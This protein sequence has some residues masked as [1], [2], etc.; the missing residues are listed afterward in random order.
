MLII[1]YDAFN[2]SYVAEEDK[3]VSPK[4]NHST[5]KKEAR[6]KKEATWSTTATMAERIRE[7]THMSLTER[8]RQEFG[9]D[10]IEDE[11]NGNPD[12][13]ASSPPPPPPPPPP[14]ETLSLNTEIVAAAISVHSMVHLP[15]FTPGVFSPAGQ[16]QGFPPVLPASGFAVFDNG[17]KHLTDEHISTNILSP[18][19][20]QNLV[21]TKLPLLPTPAPGEALPLLPTVAQPQQINIPSRVNAQPQR[22]EFPM[23]T[24]LPGGND[25]VPAITPDSNS[26][27]QQIGSHNFQ[28]MQV[29]P[30]HVQ[31][32]RVPSLLEVSKLPS[33]G[34]E[35]KVL[36]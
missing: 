28:S 4:K 21:S 31:P 27:I 1:E 24:D 2:L 5:D 7:Q 12:D 36:P 32:E 18:P 17:A 11:A 13:P 29:N 15:K 14:S 10:N 9:L 8:L 25:I 22:L 6:R 33:Y 19:T 16:L 20:P 26:L 34:Y 3:A 30:S 35:S 23:D